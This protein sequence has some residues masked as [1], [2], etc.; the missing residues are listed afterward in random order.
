MADVIHYDYRLIPIIGR[1][2]VEYG[3]GNK[4]V[5]TVCEENNI[6]KWF[7]LEIINSFRNHQYFP[8][9]QLQNF[10]AKVIIQYLSNTHSYYLEVKVPEIQSYIDE[11][12]KKVSPENS[13]NVKLLNNFF[14]EYKEELITHLANEDNRVYPYIISL[15]EAFSQKN[16]AQTLVDKIKTDPI[17]K[18][19]R[20][21]DDLE[22]KLSDLKINH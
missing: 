14:K 16:I 12:E 15:E 9:K 5:E 17:E 6:N 22:I 3:F 2:G 7:F 10:T 18:Y 21:H 11:M 1:F 8:Q 13:K 20:N 4:T 19:E